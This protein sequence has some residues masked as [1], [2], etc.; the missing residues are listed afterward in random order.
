[1]PDSA[2]SSWPTGTRVWNYLWDCPRAR[3]YVPDIARLVA[4][5]AERTQAQR[6][7]LIAFSCGSPLLADALVEL[8]EAHPDEDADALQRRF[9]IANAIFVAADIDLQTFARSH[10]P[11]PAE[12]LVEWVRARDGDHLFVY[13]FAG[14]HVH[15]GLGALVAYRLARAAPV[16]FSWNMNDYGFMLS[17]RRFAQPTVDALR[18]AFSPDGLLDDLMASLN[19]GELARRQFREIARVAG[20]VF[21]GLPHKAKSLRQLQASSGLIYDVLAEHDPGHVLMR[22]AV[23]EV[24]A[25]QLEYRRLADA[26]A[27]IARRAIVL[28]APRTLT[29]LSF[30]L[31]ADFIRGALS[32]EDWLTRVR[33]MAERLEAT[34]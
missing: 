22:Q 6:L 12:L 7:N 9:R 19:L 13:P 1:M 4:L 20:L 25:N 30:P 23:D 2:V 3:A 28:E 34:V 18:A 14:R 16:T 10:L 11:A 26:L 29:P 17:A 5:V 32:T 33:A 8:R 21:Q 31:W 27:A 24:L 15:E